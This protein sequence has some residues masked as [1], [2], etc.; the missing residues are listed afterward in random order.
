MTTNNDYPYSDFNLREARRQQLLTMYSKHRG[1]RALLLT[2]VS[3]GG[4][5][6]DAQERVIREMLIELLDLQLDEKRHVKHNTYTGLDYRYNEVLDEILD[7]AENHEFEVLCLDVLDRGLGRKGVSREIFRAQLRELG[8]HILTTEPSDHSDDDSLEGQLMRLLK[9]Y[10]AEEEIN[11]FVRRSKNAI[12]HK[13]LGEPEKGVPPQ[14][15]GNGTRFYGYKFV[16]NSQGKRGLLELNNDVVLV[17]RKGVTWSEVRVIAFAFRCAKRRIPLRRICRRLNA[18]G[19]PAPSISI[20]KKYKSK[21]IQEAKPI[22]QVAVLSRMLR[23]RRFSGKHVVNQYHTERVPGKKSRR[24]RKTAPESQIIVPVPGIVSVELQEEVI[25]N[26]QRNQKVSRRNNK[27]ST[28]TLLRG[29]LGKCGN[30]GRNLSTQ[31]RYNYYRGERINEPVNIYRCST[32]SSGTL[33]CC[34]GCYYFASVLDEAVWKKA[35]EII[36]KPSIV[37]EAIERRKTSD[38]TASRRRQI[39]KKIAEIRTERDNLQTNLLRLIREQ[40]LDRNTE[41]VLTNRLKDLDREEKD[42]HS[43]LLDDEKIY[44]EWT[45]A[46]EDLEKIR[47]RCA[48]ERERMSDPNYKPSYQTKRDFVELLGITVTLWEKGHNP[49]YK[50]S[51]NSDDI[52]VQLRSR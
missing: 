5:S 6:H 1:K 51:V 4:Q 50:I 15:I 52:A 2:R 39:S 44:R 45:K 21:G 12:R 28:L 38:P 20:G 43:E 49:R 16:L 42:Y 9:G 33:H 27:Q 18:I 30:C 32:K 8:I 40:K 13:A 36:E 41:D 10:K 17:D 3:T 34:K 25:A 47:K 31:V 24:Y 35:L 26:L 48:R 11:D 22:W 7:M 23:N 19:I 29:G 14:V 37:D 46:Q